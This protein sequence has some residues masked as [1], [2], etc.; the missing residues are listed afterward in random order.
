M[1]DFN[2]S[3]PIAYPGFT[4]LGVV[5]QSIREIVVQFD[6]RYLPALSRAPMQY[7]AQADI[8]TYVMQGVFESKVP[9]QLPGSMAFEAFNG[10]NSFQQLFVAAPSV[11][12]SPFRLNF[13][14]PFV[15]ENGDAKLKDFYGASTLP[16]TYVDAGRAHKARMLGDFRN[17]A[18]GTAAQG[19]TI[20][21]PGFPNG[22]PLYTDG[23]ITSSHFSHP[24]QKGSV[25]FNNLFLTAGKFTS[26]TLLDTQANMA[27]IAHPTIPGMP[28]GYEVHHIKGP[29]W[30]RK[31]FFRV[32]L[33]N[34]ELQVKTV[35]S[36]VAGAAATNIAAIDK[37]KELGES[38]FIGAS[39]VGPVTYHID[40][41]MDGH[42]L[43]AAS[44]AA[45]AA[46]GDPSLLKDF[47]EA[48]DGTPE[49]APFANFLAPDVNFVPRVRLLGDQSEEAIK[50]DMIRIFG[51]LDA[52]IGAGW[53][54]GVALYFEG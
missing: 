50:Y 18:Y 48:V 15:I 46:A 9:M 11:Q 44:K 47:W 54:G 17:V 41:T 51:Q 6:I 53:P 38:S 37:L 36:S 7:I 8:G 40:P 49:T 33:A 39:G 3:N 26:D 35:G 2:G 12:T 23:V 27:N 22:L 43:V 34:L 10:D 4:G 30:M 32:A 1:A 24:F 19:L 42:P 45:A 29:T 52:G 21:Q 20:P 25:R 14:W 13:E 5:A 28:A 16:K 31:P